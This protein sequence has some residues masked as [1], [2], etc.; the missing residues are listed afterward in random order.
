MPEAVFLGFDFGFKRIGTAIGQRL[1]GGASPLCTIAAKQGV[2]DWTHIQQLIEEWKPCELIVGLPTC[3]DDRELYTTQAARQ[4]AT[5]LQTR[6]ALPV[7]CVDERLTTVEAR[8]RL[9]A[10]GGYRKIKKTQVDCLA[11]CIILEQWLH[12]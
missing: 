4:F 3:I 10:K 5:E 12:E 11:A 1:T 8:E 7:H 2:P 6:F 9:Y